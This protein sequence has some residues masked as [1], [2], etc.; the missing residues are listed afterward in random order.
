[1]DTLFDLNNAI[2]GWLLGQPRQSPVATSLGPVAIDSRQVEPGD[3]FWALRGPH[4]DGA[5]FADEAFRR[6][7]A[8]AVV[9]RPVAVPAGQWAI[10]TA[11]TQQALRR[12]AEWKRRRFTGTVIAVTGSV[13]KTTTRQMIHTALH[14]RLQGTA[15][16][17][18]YNNHLGVPLSLLAVEPQHDYTVLELGASRRGEIA[19]LAELCRP[20]VGVIT[21][22]GD[23]HLGGFGSRRAIAEAKAELLSALPPDGRAV[24]GDDPWLR[25]VAR[26]RRAEITWVGTNTDCDLVA[27]NVQSNH[28]QLRFRVQDRDFCVPVWGRHHL[29]NDLAAVAV[30]RMMGLDLAGIA[31]SL[32]GFQPVPMRCEVL[33][34]RGATI[35]NDT[36]NSNP[37]AMRAALALLHEFDAAGRRIIVCGDMAELG[38]E[39]A[40]LHWQLGKQIVTLGSAEMLIACG[41]H[42]RHVVAG[43]RAAG[44]PRARAIPCD[45]V[46]AALPFLGQAI[47]PGDVVLVKGSRMMAMERVVQALESFPR[48]RSA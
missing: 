37:T 18:N 6:G 8:G 30:G 15:S 24:L 22:I 7:A 35:I 14:R 48:R 44:M 3:V 29:P 10:Q 32:E 40:A 21:Q 2:G 27:T 19:A 11:D 47:Q 23:A 34:V 43:A 41:E 4:H 45:T 42:A 33:E 46:E 28:G 39:S 12:W 25:S 13:G 9:S 38:D 36:Y 26:G 31:E 5:E 16:P 1:M 17:G 20:K